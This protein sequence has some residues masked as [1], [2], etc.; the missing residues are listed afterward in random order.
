MFFATPVDHFFDD[1]LIVDTA[2]AAQS[3]QH[4][5]E[6]ALRLLGQRAEP[7]KRK[8]MS[9]ANVALGIHIDVASAASQL[10]VYAAPVP[11]RIVSILS[12]IAGCAS[13][14]YMSPGMAAT[15]RGKLGFI[16]GSSYYRFG[17]AALQPLMQ[18]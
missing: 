6:V 13:S 17:R 3:G 5:V 2:V 14:D 12:F 1:F 18:R 10:V 4:C 11:D 9:G 7:T 16:F 8:R 15:A